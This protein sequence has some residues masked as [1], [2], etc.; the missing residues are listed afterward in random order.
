MTRLFNWLSSEQF[1]LLIVMVC[2][3]LGL[4]LLF[5]MAGGVNDG[6]EPEPPHHRVVLHSAVRS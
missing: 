2:L 1:A 5:I 3:L 4:P 6:D